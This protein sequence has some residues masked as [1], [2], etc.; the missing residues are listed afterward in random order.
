MLRS[1]LYYECHITIEPVFD[2]RLRNFQSICGS[3]GF[4]A[5]DLLM[6]KRD[7]DTAERSQND[8]FATGRDNAYEHLLTRMIGLVAALRTNGYQ[9]WRYKIED[10]LLDSKAEGDCLK[11]GVTEH[12]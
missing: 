6:K 2:V 1:R 9:V 11:L 12:A 8:T 3:F 5:A 10:T 4:R 7:E